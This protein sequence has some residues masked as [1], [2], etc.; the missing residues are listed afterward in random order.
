MLGK[1]LEANLG[2]LPLAGNHEFEISKKTD[3][4]F[5]FQSINN[6]QRKMISIHC[7]ENKEIF[8]EPNK[9]VEIKS[10]KNKFFFKKFLYLVTDYIRKIF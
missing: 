3:F 4:N 1:L 6:S 2:N 9:D 10:V 5:V 7:F 8:N